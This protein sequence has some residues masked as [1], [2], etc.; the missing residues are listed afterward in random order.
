M[1]NCILKGLCI[2]F[3]LLSLIAMFV[4]IAFAAQDGHGGSTEVIARIEA[5]TEQTT[6]QPF[7]EP[8]SPTDSTPVQTGG[9]A[10]W[11]ILSVVCMA[12]ALL[13]IYRIRS[14]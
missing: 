12:A 13:L 3:M 2:F 9:S 1:K 7:T 14:G 4:P 6:A 8:L 5:P 11:I 10:I